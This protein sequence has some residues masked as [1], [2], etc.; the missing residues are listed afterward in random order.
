[1]R[2]S[3]R[4]LSKV[5]GTSRVV[6]QIDFDLAAGEIRALVGENGAGK[7]T[8]IK[9]IAGA[10]VPSHGAVFLDGRPLPVGEPARVRRAGVTVVYQEFTL[11]PELSVA[12]NIFLGQEQGSLWLRREPMRRRAGAIL[13]DLDVHVDPAAL[14]ADLNMG[15]R[16]M[17]EVARAVLADA[18][19]VIFDE[20]TAALSASEVQKLLRI[21]QRIAERGTSIIYVS[22][23]LEEVLAA[24]HTVTV[25]RD[26]R[27]VATEPTEGC[28]R[29]RLVRLMV[30]RDLADE[31]PPR[32]QPTREPLLV[33]RNLS[34]P[35]RFRDLSFDVRRGEIVG[36]AGLVGSGRTT[37]GLALGG[38]IRSTGSISLGGQPLRQ[39]APAAAL[40]RGIAYVTEDRKGKGIFAMLATDE[41]LAMSELSAWARYGWLRRR[42][43]RPRVEA[44]ARQVDLRTDLQQVAGTLSGGNQQKAL[45]GRYLLNPPA[46]L[47]LD[48][49][50]RGVDVGARAEIYA[51]MNDL[52]RKGIGIIMIS[53]DL[54]EILGMSDRILVM[55]EGRLS[56][57]LTRDAATAESVMT[58]ATKAV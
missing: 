6:D 52:T 35:P 9:M 54:G 39:G 3:T 4:G 43:W 29:A 27:H 38:A 44:V 37:V 32:A 22:H 47:I 40:R 12:E 50:T 21:I 30:G 11:V 53:S 49:P 42:D 2:L 57:E 25:L 34:A 10:T 19:V 33:V 45:L 17:V 5:Y 20:P 23:R 13:A 55:R 7:S 58:L 18:Q 51:I 24:A 48:E 31:Y 15:H 14:V 1:M 56:G 36:I 46:V 26:G 8:F 41:N 16:Q 28:D